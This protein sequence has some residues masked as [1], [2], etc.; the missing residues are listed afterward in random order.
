MPDTFAV[1]LCLAG[2][3]FGLNFFLPKNSLAPA[4]NLLLFFLLGTLGA[5]CKLPTGFIFSLF[6]LPLFSKKIALRRKL[7]FLVAGAILLTING[8][9]YF[10]WLPHLIQTYGYEHYPMRHFWQGAREI[11]ANLPE[12]AERFY[13]SGLKSYLGFGLYLAGVVLIFWKKNRLLIA[14]FLLL[15]LTFL[16]YMFKAGSS[17][18]H[19]NYYIIPFAPVMALLAAFALQQIPKAWL[20]NLLL[21]AIAVEGIANQ[22]DA[23]RVPKKEWQKLKLE[24]IADSVSQRSDL[25]AFHNEEANPQELYFAHRKGWL[26]TQAQLSD[27]AFR[28]SLREKGCRFVFVNKLKWNGERLAEEVVFEDE[29]YFVFRLKADEIQ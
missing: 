17:F 22:Q 27:P 15:S 12:M 25:A 9:W 19:H 10:Y 7:S 14:S 26:A 21:L 8:W 16:G 1:S 11:F 3:Y 4:A 28:R 2:L 5:L 18:Y 24:A 20:R 29:N 6:L 13:I 23:F